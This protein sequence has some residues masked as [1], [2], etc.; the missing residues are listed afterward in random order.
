MIWEFYKTEKENGTHAR[1]YDVQ[2]NGTSRLFIFC[3]DPNNQRMCHCQSCGI[4]IPREVP[5][6]KLD[7]AYHY[8]AG[9]YCMSCGVK[10]LRQKQNELKN[11]SEAMD[12]VVTELE[13][14]QKLAKKVMENEF[15]V[16]KMAL[17]KMFQVMEENQNGN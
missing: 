2:I 1:A 9:Y 4:K 3:N 10:K 5:R 6:V 11:V 8:G 12:K 17:G 7:A 15:Y 13:D 16:Q 14:L